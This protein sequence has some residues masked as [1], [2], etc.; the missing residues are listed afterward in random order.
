MPLGN[1]AVCTLLIGSFLMFFLPVEKLVLKTLDIAVSRNT[2][3]LAVLA[4][5]ALVLIYFSGISEIVY[6]AFS[7]FCLWAFIFGFLV[8]RKYP[9]ILA[10]IFLASCPFLLIAKLDAVAEFLAVLTYLCLALG[11]L[12]DIFY[13]KI[14]EGGSN[15]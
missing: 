13:D 3:S 5:T 2:T 15:E 11:V 8:D 4:I 12:K 1:I 9:Y 7:T 10:F 6:L 14:V